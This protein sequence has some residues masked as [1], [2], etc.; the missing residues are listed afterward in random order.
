MREAV[1]VSA[2]RT[3]LA[4]FGGMFKDI[5]ARDLA[6]AAVKEAVKRANIAPNEVDELI[7]AKARQ[8]G[9]GPNIGRQISVKSGLPFEVPAYTVNKACGSSIQTIILAYQAIALNDADII[10]AGGV[11]SMTRVP[12]MLDRARFDGYR[13]GHGELID[14]MYRDGF[15]CPL[16]EMLMGRTAENL[17]EKYN[18]SRKEQDE[19]AVISHKKAYEATTAGKFKDEIVPYELQTKDGPKLVNTDEPV[20]GDTTLE[21]LAKLPT[22]FKENGT[23]TPGNA[24]GMTDG[25]AAVVVMSR[26]T[27]IKKGIKP[28]AKIEAYTSAGVDPK[29]MGIGPVPATN[30]L[31]QKTGT[32]MKDYDLFELNEAFAAQV[33]AVNKELPFPQDRTNVNGGAIALGHPIGCTGARLVATLTYEMQKRNAKRGLITLCLSGGMGMSLSLSRPE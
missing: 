33:I 26:E 5:P 27:A 19:Y 10:V 11:E 17:A 9:Q 30:K 28:L 15:F 12:Y 3:P 29:Y 25:A 23:V 31:F 13:L 4:R 6:V 20:R 32:S 24:C 22:V 8:A 14:G 21:K 1:I 18:I 2:V 16:A 7:F